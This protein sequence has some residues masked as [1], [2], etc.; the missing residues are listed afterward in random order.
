[1]R[2]KIAVLA[3]VL[4][5]AMATAAPAAQAVTFHEYGVPLPS[6]VPLEMVGG[7]T[8][9]G[10]T[11]GAFNCDP[12]KAQAKIGANKANPAT[13]T[14]FSAS[15][16]CVGAYGW[17]L[18]GT[19]EATGPVEVFSN[20]TSKLPLKMITTTPGNSPCTSTGTG[21][22]TGN[23]KTPSNYAA[24]EAFLPGNCGPLTFAT[25]AKLQRP[26]GT[27]ITLSYP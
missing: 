2:S 26:S 6:T 16:N 12:W 27:S 14:G 7:G 10:G 15:L 11:L 23:L 18:T 13:L 4:A 19:M 25:V 8:N 5:V 20:G 24:I 17:P 9:I 1:M 22:F 3:G 21:T